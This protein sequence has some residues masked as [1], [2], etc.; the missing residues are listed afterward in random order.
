MSAA[1]RT[2]EQH[3]EVNLSVRRPTVPGFWFIFLPS[4]LCCVLLS[5][6]YA[7]VECHYAYF[8]LPAGLESEAPL[9]AEFCLRIRVGKNECTCFACF[10][11]CVPW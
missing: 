6:H 1:S 2:Q 3:P 9:N 10:A 4:S 8:L 7:L 5:S 11:C